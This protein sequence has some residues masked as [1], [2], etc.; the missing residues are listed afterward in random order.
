MFT[1]YIVS[2]NITAH[3]EALIFSYFIYIDIV[4][5]S[6]YWFLIP[7]AMSVYK[8]LHFKNIHL[9][10]VKLA[11]TWSPQISEALQVGLVTD[12]REIAGS[13]PSCGLTIHRGNTWYNKNWTAIPATRQWTK[14]KKMDG[15]ECLWSKIHLWRTELSNK[16]WWFSVELLAD[17]Q[18]YNSSYIGI[19]I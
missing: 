5:M 13:L 18:N 19:D 6:L 14:R 10:T 12:S 16:W 7:A 3:S 1:D 9:I 11:T 17:I 15:C 2:I 4:V 8:M